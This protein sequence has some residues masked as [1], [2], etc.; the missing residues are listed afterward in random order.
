MYINLMSVD[1]GLSGNFGKVSGLRFQPFIFFFDSGAA[2]LHLLV[3]ASANIKGLGGTKETSELYQKWLL[4]L[5]GLFEPS[6]EEQKNASKTRNHNAH[7]NPSSRPAET[8]FQAE[9]VVAVPDSLN[10]EAGGAAHQVEVFE[11]LSHVVNV[12]PGEV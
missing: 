9:T 10:G 3:S 6:Q 1:L 5:L 2:S 11:D 12:K 7:H 8:F 4:M